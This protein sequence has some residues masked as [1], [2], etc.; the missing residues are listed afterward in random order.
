MGLF[1][2]VQN[3][4]NFSYPHTVGGEIDPYGIECSIPS[5]ASVRNLLPEVLD[6]NEADI[7]LIG[8]TSVSVY[9]LEAEKTLIVMTEG[10]NGKV[11]VYIFE[12]PTLEDYNDGLALHN[13]DESMR[14]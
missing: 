8:G 2:D 4:T 12:Y 11:Y 14:A 5:L 10:S 13:P 7:A 6:H 1:L 9:G 3:L